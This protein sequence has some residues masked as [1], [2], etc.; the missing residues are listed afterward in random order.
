M[1]DNDCDAAGEVNRL[2]EAIGIPYRV[3]ISPELSELLKPNTF[4]SGLGIRYIDRIRL[5]L[6]IL[7]GNLI[8]GNKSPDEILPKK[9]LIIPMS[10]TK[11]PYISEEITSVRA[12]LTDDDGEAGILLTAILE[13]E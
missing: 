12:E 10:L 9:G 2:S 13:E 1:T 6:G 7:K 11:G 3:E 5:I 8:P 4:L